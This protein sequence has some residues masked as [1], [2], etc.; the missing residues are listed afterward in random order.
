MH[1]N[2]LATTVVK[3]VTNSRTSQS[4]GAELQQSPSS[5]IMR[6]LHQTLSGH[7]NHTAAR[8]SITTKLQLAFFF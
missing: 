7:L 5:C 8:F 1:K 2:D 3:L 6:Q 4:C